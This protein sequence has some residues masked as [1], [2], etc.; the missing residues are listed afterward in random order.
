MDW[1][2]TMVIHRFI[3]VWF[4]EDWTSRGKLKMKMNSSKNY[5][6]SLHWSSSPLSFCKI[7]PLHKSLNF[8]VLPSEAWTSNVDTHDSHSCWKC[9]IKRRNKKRIKILSIYCYSSHHVLIEEFFLCRFRWTI[10]PFEVWPI[11]FTNQLYYKLFHCLIFSR[12]NEN[13]NWKKKLF[14]Y[15]PVQLKGCEAKHVVAITIFKLGENLGQDVYKHGLHRNINQ[16]E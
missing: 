16:R 3:E 15:P 13:K 6:L 2:R 12:L 5:I 4:E 14:F 10:T 7:L 9:K 1:E 11:N 8:I